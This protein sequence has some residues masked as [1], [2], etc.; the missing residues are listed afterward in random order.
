MWETETINRWMSF[1]GAK[2]G[3]PDQSVV[4]TQSYSV[5]TSL[6]SPPVQVARWAQSVQ[7]CPFFR[8]KSAVYTGWW[9]VPCSVLHCRYTE[10]IPH[11][12][13]GK[14]GIS[15]WIIWL[16]MAYSLKVPRVAFLSRILV[17]PASSIND[18]LFEIKETSHWNSQRKMVLTGDLEI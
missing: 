5:W 11:F 14:K 9:A 2:S 6:L 12:E 1:P 15:S 16:K 10:C 13:T 17:L 8:S 18:L 7:S 4:Y 3:H